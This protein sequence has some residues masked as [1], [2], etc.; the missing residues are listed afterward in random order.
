MW[1]SVRKILGK[2]LDMHFLTASFFDIVR[3][4]ILQNT[5][6]ERVYFQSSF[7]AIIRPAFSLPELKLYRFLYP[8]A[9]K[10]YKFL[11]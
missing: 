7:T 3:R 2:K 8:L 11:F 5:V 1:N 6:M 10:L 4:D 9:P